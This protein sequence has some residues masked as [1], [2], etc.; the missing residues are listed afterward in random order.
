M[1]NLARSVPVHCT[2]LGSS[3]NRL[4]VKRSI[5]PDKNF[6]KRRKSFLGEIIHEVPGK[7]TNLHERVRYIKTQEY[8]NELPFLQYSRKKLNDLHRICSSTSNVMVWIQDCACMTVHDRTF[9]VHVHAH[10]CTYRSIHGY[11]ARMCKLC[12]W[13]KPS[14]VWYLIKIKQNLHEKNYSISSI[15]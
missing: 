8:L 15:S 10:D 11:V 2:E 6:C 9:C 1:K 12:S 7:S 14:F 4:W 3:P 13:S 5:W